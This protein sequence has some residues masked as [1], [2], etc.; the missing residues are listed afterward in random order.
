MRRSIADAL[1]EAALDPF[2]G[3]NQHA[4]PNTRFIRVHGSAGATGYL[5]T[6]IV[7]DIPKMIAVFGEPDHADQYK[8]S[9]EWIF[10]D[11][12]TDS[13]FTLYDWKLT[14]LY[15]P[16]AQWTPQDL[17]QMPVSMNVGGRFGNQRGTAAPAHIGLEQDFLDFLRA[18]GVAQ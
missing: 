17:R 10:H 4:D 6:N 18:S 7:I 16:N 5:G 3:I 8:V 2:G 14:T 15:D 13:F 9:M 11:T 1:I 12:Q